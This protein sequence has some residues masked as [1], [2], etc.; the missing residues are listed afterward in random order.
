[1]RLLW[2][3]I[4]RLILETLDINLSEDRKL[5]KD[6]REIL[7]ELK[8]FFQIENIGLAPKIFLVPDRKTINAL[9]GEKQ[10]NWLLG[11]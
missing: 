4:T 7:E 11:G 9:R 6:C 3:M 2:V 5:K 1:M 10:K 8:E